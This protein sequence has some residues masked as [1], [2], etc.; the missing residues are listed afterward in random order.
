MVGVGLLAAALLASAQPIQRAES[1]QVNPRAADST[2]RGQ[3]AQRD[4]GP[5]PS[6][7]QL[8]G[9][10]ET[11]NQTSQTAQRI[12]EDRALAQR[13]YRLN[14][15]LAIA[16]VITL[17]VLG[18][19]SYWL[20]RDVTHAERATRIGLRAYLHPTVATYDDGVQEGTVTVKNFGQTP[21]HDL[22]VILRM[23]SGAREDFRWADNP[24]DTNEIRRILPAGG[25]RQY[26]FGVPD[27][28]E[29][30]LA[31]LS[32]GSVTAIRVQGRIL[33]KDVFGVTCMTDF[34]AGADGNAP[35]RGQLEFFPDRN[36]YT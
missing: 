1:V 11:E 29:R 19:Q 15:V 21:A 14:V 9:G 17:I 25:E 34:L 26:T 27:L 23:F 24:G 36:T 30:D 8:V 31:K 7:E 13:G 2:Q 22:R 28:T 32:A 18:V 6:A 5:L 4:T 16:A 12:A 33:Y 20:R 3:R 35:E 10:S